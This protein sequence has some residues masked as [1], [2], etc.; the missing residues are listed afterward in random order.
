MPGYFLS[1]LFA[2]LIFLPQGQAIAYQPGGLMPVGYAMPH[3][4]QPS[5]HD[6][7]R[8]PYNPY[9]YRGVRTPRA[10]DASQARYATP[11]PVAPVVPVVTAS[12][13]PKQV[14]KE[15][16]SSQPRD[17]SRE[18][19]QQT[20]TEQTKQQFI[21]KLIP[22]IQKENRRLQQ[23]R[24]EVSGLVESLNRGQSLKKPE[25]ERLASLAKQYRL[26]GDPLKDR[27]A[28]NDLV[29]RI[30]IIPV[31]LALAQA[32][33]ESGWGRSR[34]AREGKNLFG[35][36]TYDK[37]KGLVPKQ[38]TEGKTHLVRKFAS[39]GESVRYYMHNLNS[40]PAYAELRRIRGEKRETG[41]AL[42]G[43][44]LA[45]GLESYSAQGERYIRL[46]Q[47]VIQ[48]NELALLDRHSSQA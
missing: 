31:S 48:Q 29:Q 41:V 19:S 30:D 15:R 3:P 47:R 44:D 9:V 33:T 28:R 43:M 10:A 32:A 7:G 16:P 14:E 5:S 2:A 8:R 24:S 18:T 13:A 6:W 1:L 23:L 42:S 35:I 36:W 26:K 21:Q 37:S 20:N 38:R 25:R 46:I 45:K 4:R 27:T 39:L 34:F 12:Q 40:H 17:K 22:L 11:A